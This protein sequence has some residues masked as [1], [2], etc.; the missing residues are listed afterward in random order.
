MNSFKPSRFNARSQSS[1]GDLVLYNSLSGAIGVVDQENRAYVEEILRQKNIPCH[2]LE[3]TEVGRTLI[4]NHYFVNSKMD[5]L[6]EAEKFH[7][8]Y[9]ND[10]K[11]MQLII[12]PTEECNFRCKYCYESFKRGQMAPNV[13][14][15]VKNLI[16][17]KSTHLDNLIISWFGGEP[18]EAPDVVFEISQHA[19]RMCEINN[20]QFRSGMTT[21]GYNLNPQLFARLIECNV[22]HYQI[23][24]DGSKDNH[25]RNRVLRYGGGT[26][27]TIV[28]NLIEMSHTDYD[29]R[30]T[31]RVNFTPDS[32]TGM[33]LFIKKLFDLLQ[34]DNRFSPFFQ[35]VGRW[36]GPNDDELSVCSESDA[37]KERYN[38]FDKA[39]SIGFS[40]PLLSEGLIP[41]G[42][43]CYAA[44]PW[45]FV[46]GSGG[47]LHKCTVALDDDRNRVGFL[48]QDGTLMVNND[49]FDLWV[50]QNEETD[51]NCQ[52]CFFRPAC[53][54]AACPLE[55]MRSGESPCPPVKKHIKR[56]LGA[57]I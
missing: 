24:V 48:N 14:E 46:I 10:D 32:L 45:S 42:S 28:H 2:V 11:S 25:D 5:E 36:G 31:L 9:F 20:V 15:G 30:V 39:R 49:K 26:F 16:T 37:L 47:A 7:Q 43:V 52:R 4:E 12:L 8:E 29:F 54:G 40:A 57:I 56:A 21:N 19:Q 18:T 53:Q 35:A 27:E 6:T 23:T 22:R 34:G 50:H 41:G 44:K 51:H 55:R 13:I 33:E 1:N 3:D 17:Q 38:L